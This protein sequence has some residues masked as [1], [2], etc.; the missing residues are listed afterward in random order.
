M[1]STRQARLQAGALWTA[2]AAAAGAGP[3]ARPGRARAAKAMAAA[4][5][6]A[7]R[8]VLIWVV[9][10]IMTPGPPGPP[11]LEGRRLMGSTI[12]PDRQALPGGL[13]IAWPKPAVA[14]LQ[15]SAHPRES[16]D[17]GIFVCFRGV[18]RRGLPVG[19]GW[20]KAWV[21]AFAGMSG[22]RDCP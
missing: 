12:D 7:R 18:K 6:S 15:K 2:G 5:P 19:R 14:L 10:P 1:M 4:P 8:W 21:P 22:G 13:T 3:S 9:L 16:G 11:A 20:E 17:P